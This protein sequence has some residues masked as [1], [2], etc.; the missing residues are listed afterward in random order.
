MIIDTQPHA[1]RI[2]QA[3][4]RLTYQLLDESYRDQMDPVENLAR[5]VAAKKAEAAFAIAYGYPVDRIVRDRRGAPDF[6]TPTGIV[7]VK[8]HAP[9]GGVTVGADLVGRKPDDFR[10]VACQVWP[11]SWAVRITGQIRM[12]EIARLPVSPPAPGHSRA[13]I[14]IPLDLLTPVEDQPSL[15]GGWAS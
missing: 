3:A 15:L 9:N 8:A 14:R 12:W 11:S 5:V 1:K 6:E 2:V 4:C 7:D 13:F 10:I